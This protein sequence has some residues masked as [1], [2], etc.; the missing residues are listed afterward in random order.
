MNKSEELQAGRLEEAPFR[1]RTREFETEP[2]QMQPR[3][4]Q[5]ER[6][7][8]KTRIHIDKSAL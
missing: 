4:K 7:T 5:T 2:E 3:G 6:F 8:P 1:R